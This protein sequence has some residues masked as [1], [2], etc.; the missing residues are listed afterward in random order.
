M[1]VTDVNTKKICIIDLIMRKIN[2]DIQNIYFYWFYAH[3]KNKTKSILIYMGKV[4][5]FNKALSFYK[6]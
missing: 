4:Q 1:C 2:I 5:I 6:Q 3:K